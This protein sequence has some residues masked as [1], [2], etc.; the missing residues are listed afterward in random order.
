M[1]VCQSVCYLD[2]KVLME[3]SADAFSYDCLIKHFKSKKKM[4]SDRSPPPND[5]VIWQRSS[6]N[7]KQD[8]KNGPTGHKFSGTQVPGVFIQLFIV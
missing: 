5:H 3:G 6:M 7:D 1:M 4:F 8:L 2:V